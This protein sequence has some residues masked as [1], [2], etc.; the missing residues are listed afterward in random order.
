MPSLERRTFLSSAAMGAA[1]TIAGPG[2][3]QDGSSSK[4][5]RVGCIGMGRR[6]RGVMRTALRNPET[7]VVAI[8]E[9]Y[10]PNIELALKMAAG[11]KGPSDGPGD[12]TASS[13]R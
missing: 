11:V 12:A 3:A 9:V 6:G 1:T 13:S 10:E 5:F 7:E 2:A 8:S 4:R